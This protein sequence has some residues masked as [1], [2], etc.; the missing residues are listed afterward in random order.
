MYVYEGDYAKKIAMILFMSTALEKNARDI[1]IVWATETK[2]RFS[3]S[4]QPVQ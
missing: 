3:N 4:S 1:Y 2:Q